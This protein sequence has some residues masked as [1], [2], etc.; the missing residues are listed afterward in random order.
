MRVLFMILCVG[1]VSSS[2]RHTD[3]ASLFKGVS[4][5]EWSVRLADSQIKREG[6]G[7]QWRETGRKKWDYAAGL[8]ALSLLA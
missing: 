2:C 4:P 8:F 3:E 1:V 6:D 5:L 7:L